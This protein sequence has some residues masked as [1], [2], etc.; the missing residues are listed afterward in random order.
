M[1]GSDRVGEQ[2][3][4]EPDF[5]LVSLIPSLPPACSY[6]IILSEVYEASPTL[7]VEVFCTCRILGGEPELFVRAD[8]DVTSCL[9]SP[10]QSICTWSHFLYLRLTPDSCQWR[11]IAPCN[12]QHQ[13]SW[14]GQPS[15]TLVSPLHRRMRQSTLPLILVLCSEWL[16][17]R[18]SLLQSRHLLVQA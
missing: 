8:V 15:S 9:K 5:W 1:E 12:H 7:S 17:R 11:I 13:P 10:S 18:N 3:T 4:M 6:L 2:G 14:R 16:K